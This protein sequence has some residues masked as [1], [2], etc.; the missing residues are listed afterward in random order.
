MA[1]T[2]ALNETDASAVLSLQALT[3]PAATHRELFGAVVE[4]TNPALADEPILGRLVETRR[5]QGVVS[6]R[7][8]TDH[9]DD[10]RNR[11]SSV[12]TANARSAGKKFDVVVSCSFGTCEHLSVDAP[13]AAPR[14]R[15]RVLSLSPSVPARCAG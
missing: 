5:A 15:Y 2:G 11:P 1:S 10:A 4:E 6:R 9:A 14:W 8:V 3:R 12:R 13:R 7:F